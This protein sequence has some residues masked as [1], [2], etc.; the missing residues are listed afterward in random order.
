MSS[1]RIHNETTNFWSHFLGSLLFI[2][3]FVYFT[4]LFAPL[5]FDLDIIDKGFAYSHSDH[6]LTDGL[7]N[8]IRQVA[9]SGKNFTTN[10]LS[11]VKG[12]KMEWSMIKI[13]EEMKNLEANLKVRILSM[14]STK[15]EEFS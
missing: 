6:N 1:C 10:S 5:D 3:L 13:I 4:I 2:F 9:T 11:W 14:N 12:V 7:V 8:S 15:L